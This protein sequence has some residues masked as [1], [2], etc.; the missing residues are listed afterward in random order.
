MHRGRKGW[1]GEAG[2][3]Q[4]LPWVGGGNHL[5]ASALLLRCAPTLRLRLR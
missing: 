4:Y 2:Y 5:R 3:M 1:E